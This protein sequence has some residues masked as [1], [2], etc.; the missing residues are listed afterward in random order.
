MGEGGLATGCDASMVSLGQVLQS[1]VPDKLLLVSALL[2]HGALANPITEL[3]TV[4]LEEALCQDNLPVVKKLI[5]NGA[6]PC[7]STVDKG[8]AI[9]HKALRWGLKNGT[10][11]D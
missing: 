11:F 10:C 6:N 3:D 4:P 9:I 2:R 8:G 5:D 1:T 7:V